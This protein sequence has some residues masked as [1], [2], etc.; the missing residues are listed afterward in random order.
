MDEAF[1]ALSRFER[2]A[3]RTMRWLNSWR[4]A[5]LWQRYVLIPFVALFVSRRLEVRGLDRVP[6]DPQARI[7]LVANHR[8]FFDLFV[9]G[10]ILWQRAG[11][12]QRLNFPVRANFFYEGPL[13]L[14]TCM[15]MSGGSMFPPFFRA[16]EK[17]VFNKYSLGV[18]IDMLKKPGQLIGFHPEGTRS[19]TDDPYTLLPAQPGAGELA[20]KAQPVV[21]PAFITGLSNSVWK[22]LRAGLF[23]GRTVVAVFGEPIALPEVPAETRL[24]HHKRCADMFTERIA[25]LAE[26]EKPL[27]A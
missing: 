24:T 8:T 19:K 11:L 9:L 6:R 22:E 13:G 23:G 2:F 27:R 17:K 10:F 1:T 14:L 18:L 21:V 4:P 7:L 5:F 12:K 26:E 25:A 16:T 3:F 15:S 20:I